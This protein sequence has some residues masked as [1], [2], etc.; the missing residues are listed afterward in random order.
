MQYNEVN[1]QNYRGIRSCHIKD[2]NLV[3]LFFGKNN[4][5]KSSLLESIFILSGPSN[6]TLPIVVN[7]VRS[8][9]GSK[10]ENMLIDF[11]QIDSKN[12]IKISSS[13]NNKR[14][15]E[16]SML[17]SQ[18]KDISLDNLNQIN[19]E[20]IGKHYGLKFNF[21]VG[22]EGKHYHTELLVKEGSG[23]TGKIITDKNYKEEMFTRF[24][25]SS[26]NQA[27]EHEMLAEIIKNK[28]E[29]A[30]IDALR[31]VEPKIKNIQLV[32]NA[33]MVDV[34]Y[35][36]LL[37]INVLG[38]GVRKILNITLSIHKCSNGILLVDEID[39]GLHHSVMQKLWEVIMK[40]CREF[41]VQ[42]FAS[43]HS[44]DII[45]SLVQ[46]INSNH[47][48]DLPV[49]AYKLLK[50]EDDELVALRYGT[51]ELSYVIGQELEVR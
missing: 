4:C 27:N 42:F 13:G 28:K 7:N 14:D 11:Y 51:K 6:P 2:L 48:N 50:K 36:T 22:N 29:G 44:I 21:S 9:V 37:P 33:I 18:S 5:G 24:M 23:D 32:D 43:T 40:T 25:P 10:E 17:K 12:K 26:Q 38:D 47:S 46:V 45:K 16:I 39:N 20:N 35:A 49:S 1:I 30:I 8:L 3:N 15:L 34:G 31:L 19:A 41:N